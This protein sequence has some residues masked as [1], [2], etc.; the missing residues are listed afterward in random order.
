LSRA[1]KYLGF[2]DWYLILLGV[3][4]IS[5][6]VFLLIFG[7]EKEMLS[8]FPCIFI[9]MVYTAT[10]WFCVRQ[11][12]IIYHKKYD[13]YVFTIQR[14]LFVLFWML[15]IYFG[16]KISVGFFFHV[17]FIN[18]HDLL[19]ENPLT[20]ILTTG[21]LLTGMFFLYEGIY[22]FNKSRL[23]E[24][25]KNKLEK[26]TAEQKLSTLKNQVN[27][28]FLFNSLNTLVTIIPEEPQLAIK[29]VQELS[30]SYRG[31]LEVRDEK[32]IT[33]ETELHSLESYMYL[34]KTRFQGKIHIYN[35]I[36]KRMMNQFILPLSLQILIENAVKH[37][38]TSKSKP[39]EIKIH[40]D[41]QYVIVENNLQKKDQNYGSTKLGLANIKSRYKLLVNKNIEV[42]ENAESFI[43]KLPIIKHMDHEDLDH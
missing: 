32:L 41:D 27:P 38:I 15:V 26:L 17:F 8:N 4:L 37:N 9:S 1:K 22:Y 6:I 30:K 40:N 31:I 13:D 28:H 5:I 10:Y 29:F 20:E 18:L 25:E 43:V 34:L 2:N 39:L 33:I 23:I 21:I 36:D 16:V 24:I 11:F 42:I 19:V 7:P 14:M 3:P 35:K 12:L